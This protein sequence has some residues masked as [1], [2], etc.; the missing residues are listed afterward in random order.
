MLGK[1]AQ[2]PFE[3]LGHS[4]AAIAAKGAQPIATPSSHNGKIDPAL[5]G[6]RDIVQGLGSGCIA[7]ERPMALGLVM[8]YGVLEAMGATV[9]QMRVVARQWNWL[10]LLALSL[11]LVAPVQ[12]GNGEGRQGLVERTI[13]KALLRSKSQSPK[14]PEL[15][16][17]VKID[18]IHAAM[19]NFEFFSS[20]LDAPVRFSTYVLD[21][22]DHECLVKNIAFRMDWSGNG[23]DE[24]NM[25]F[26]DAFF[27][28]TEEAQI[29]LVLLGFAYG[30]PGIETCAA[31]A[32][33]FWIQF[34]RTGDYVF[35]EKD[36][37]QYSC[38]KSSFERPQK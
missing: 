30:V 10:C 8:Y 2:A 37:S 23:S 13:A 35:Y 26:C 18:E 5:Q 38:A 15:A 34:L 12:A 16:Q 7:I 36:W 29:Q 21:G 14:K 28:Q 32:Y 20:A 11:F 17:W 22:Q 1:V 31:Q 24:L 27:S 33:A 4:P 3:R 9:L 6:E 19:Q 25:R